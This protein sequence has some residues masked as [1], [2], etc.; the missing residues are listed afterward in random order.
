MSK[1]IPVTDRQYDWFQAR[2][3]G[4]KTMPQVID[5]IIDLVDR[6]EADLEKYR[7]WADASSARK[8]KG[9]ETLPLE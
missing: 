2:A 7:K 8:E 3:R 9:H 6:Y 5:H 4:R 1:T